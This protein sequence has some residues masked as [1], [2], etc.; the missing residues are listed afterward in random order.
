MTK[1]RDE[2]AKEYGTSVM[3]SMF[4]PTIDD[5]FR[6]TVHCGLI[7]DISWLSGLVQ[8]A[9]GTQYMTFRAYQKNSSSKFYL[10]KIPTDGPPQPDTSPH[11]T[12]YVWFDKLENGS[13]QIR[14]YDDPTAHFQLDIEPGK[15][16]WQEGDNIDLHYEALGPAARFL[17]L[18]GEVH[19]EEIYYAVEMCKIE[20]TIDGEKVTGFGSLD[21]VWQTA[22]IAWHQNKLYLAVED[23]WMPF[24]NRYKDGTYEYGHFLKGR[25]GWSL[26]YYVKDG[27]AHM[28]NDYTM[29][30][31]WKEG[32]PA[33][34]HIKIDDEEFTWICESVT[35]APESS[36]PHIHYAAGRMVHKGV[37]SEL[38]SHQSWIEYRPYHMWGEAANRI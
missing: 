9:D 6:T 15:Y 28:N 22:G 33:E 34:V 36:R 35:T 3:S 30:V 14:S 11:Y 38:E 26:G 27:K 24:M 2:L 25:Q 31:D 12:G 17:T 7:Y 4:T 13:V 8:T 10:V 1:T 32:H 16:H 20:G 21:Q 18:G 37:D 29:D 19:K 23:I 5:Y